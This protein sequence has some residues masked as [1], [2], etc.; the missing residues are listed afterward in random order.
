M[1]FLLDGKERKTR[2]RLCDI[3]AWHRSKTTIKGYVTE[4]EIFDIGGLFWGKFDSPSS[5]W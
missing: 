1:T 3:V 4:L 2:D 5:F